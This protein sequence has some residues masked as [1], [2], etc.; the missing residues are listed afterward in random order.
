MQLLRC[1]APPSLASASTRNLRD[2]TAAAE[3]EA[4][5]AALRPGT[6][7]EPQDW[8]VYFQ[9][10][11]A[12]YPQQ[13]DSLKG[14][15]YYQSLT[16]NIAGAIEAYR[17]VLATYPDDLASKKE[18]A[19]LL[20]VDQQLDASISLYNEILRATTDDI[21]VLENLARVYTW[22]SRPHEALE[23]YQ[24]LLTLKPSELTYQLHIARFQMEVKDSP[25]ARETLQRIIAAYPNNRDAMLLLAE[26]E[27][28]D[29]NL[30][31]ARTQYVL[32]LKEDTQDPDAL[33]GAARAAFYQGMTPEAYRRDS[34][35]LKQQPKNVDALLLM[36]TL[37]RARRNRRAALALLDETL[38]LSPAHAEAAAL[39]KSLLEAG[40]VTLRTSASYAREIGRATSFLDE[41][42]RS[43]SYG[44]GLDFSL[45]PKT[46]STLSWTLMPSSTPFGGLRGVVGPSQFFYRQV[47]QLRPG[48]TVRSGVGMVRFGSGALVGL[49]GQPE[50][51]P[52]AELRPIATVGVALQPARR[53]TFDFS[54]SRSA[55][56]Y[57]P[58]AVHLGVIED[59]WS[60][61]ANLLLT[62]RNR[63]SLSYEDGRYISQEYDHIRLSE[64]QRVVDR[65][66][67]HA[68][69][70][71][72]SILF[73]HSLIE[74]KRVSLFAGYSG[75]ASGN[76][77]P[78]VFLGFFNPTFSQEHLGVGH[79]FGT[80]WGPVG[81]DFNGGFG[82]QRSVG[83]QWRRGAQLRSAF[84]IRVTRS[85]SLEFGHSYYNT[86]Q[87]LSTL[88]GRAFFLSTNWRF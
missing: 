40:N 48:L 72:G 31:K 4:R 60:V 21:E 81:F 28:T 1:R 68:R 45:L 26:L 82:L 9:K 2:E 54:F 64:G 77:G 55:I 7:A 8:V 78:N 6:G 32:L 79:F 3:E 19:R 23:T 42:L 43:Y 73:I 51:L 71:Q 61:G 76:P 56:A 37:E 11:L 27:L 75:R 16:R 50:N 63:L 53:A 86:I 30:E 49:P 41:D 88:S 62:Q 47:T 15:A 14:L 57:T 44:V 66:A 12:A 74:N 10:R 5:W 70:H 13:G 46:D 67:D 69:M 29:H 33:F 52:S 20:S 39:R 24:K 34:Q 59:G 35:L 83:E 87:A 38:R 65:R 25:A 22:A 58:T 17:K 18:L 80:L 36:A 85:F 84:S